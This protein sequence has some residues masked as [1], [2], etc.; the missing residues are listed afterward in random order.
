MN[1]N[2]KAKFFVVFKHGFFKRVKSKAFIITN[3]I[4]FVIALLISLLPTLIDAFG[5]EFDNKYTIYYD[6]KDTEDYYTA[7]SGNGFLE[8]EDVFT[9]VVNSMD[10]NGNYVV[11]DYSD[12]D[13]ELVITED[14]STDIVIV[15]FTVNDSGLLEVTI[16]SV[17][18]LP[19]NLKTAINAAVTNVN[20]Y[21]NA[22][23][24]GLTPSEVGTITSPPSISYKDTTEITE[25][26]ENALMGIALVFMYVVGILAFM[27]LLLIIQSFGAQLLEEKTSGTIEVVYS[28]VS[29]KVH[30]FGR[31]LS[32]SVFTILQILLFG[33]YAVLASLLLGLT[34]SGSGSSDTF[35]NLS[36]YTSIIVGASVYTMI[37]LIVT[38]FMLLIVYAMLVSKSKDQED[39]AK[40]FAPVMMI[41]F[42]PYMLMMMIPAFTGS[43]FIEIISVLPVF[44][45]FIAPSLI[46]LGDIGMIHIIIS[47]VLLIIAVVLVIIW[48]NK[49]YKANM[50]GYSMQKDK[51]RKFK[52]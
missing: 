27:L 50:L 48:M 36:Q 8:L 43:N 20:I 2:D 35:N 37:V 31:I 40:K 51:K 17:D 21:F 34:V 1:S 3:V 29:A 26:D 33:L 16:N 45:V 47:I 25:E 23:Q 15:K 4:M 12:L 24:V 44:S 13:E 52:K 38:I 41:I 7:D 30:L 49:S 32:E 11:E 28:S 46:I 19:A 5:G 9:I 39:L 14:S 6:L 18:S 22:S 10:E 42:I